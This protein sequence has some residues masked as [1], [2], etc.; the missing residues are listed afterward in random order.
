MLRPPEYLQE[1][2]SASVLRREHLLQLGAPAKIAY[3]LEHQY[4]PTALSFAGLKNGDAAIGKVLSEAGRKAGC[5]VHLAI[6]HIE[7]F[8]SAEVPYEPRF[9]RHRHYELEDRSGSSNAWR[10]HYKFDE[11][12]RL[13]AAGLAEFLVALASLQAESIA[14]AAAKTVVQYP[15]VFTPQEIVVAALK[16]LVDE[17]GLEGVESSSFQA[18]WKGC[19]V[20]LLAQSEFPPAQAPSVRKA[21]SLRSACTD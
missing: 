7:E 11:C 15:T 2:E 12:T 8:G 19:A 16:G 17:A 10:H 4:T 9:R 3:L 14:E 5:T 13:T 20:F 21:E 18:L 6:V 1:T